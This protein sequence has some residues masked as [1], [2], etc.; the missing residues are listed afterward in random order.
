MHFD[1][2]S[3]AVENRDDD[4]TSYFLFFP[5]WINYFLMV[6]DDDDEGHYKSVARRRRRGKET[7]VRIEPTLSSKRIR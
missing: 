7:G 3:P 5:T 1:C 2:S 6:F 4:V